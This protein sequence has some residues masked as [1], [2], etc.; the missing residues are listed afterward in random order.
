MVNG[1]KY[2]GEWQDDNKHGHGTYTRANGNKYEGEFRNDK[3]NG[4]GTFTLANKDKYEGEWQ[5]N[6]NMAMEHILGQMGISMKE[7]GKM[8]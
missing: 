7:N 8:V 6:K 4:H 2:D 5:D 1:D 3:I